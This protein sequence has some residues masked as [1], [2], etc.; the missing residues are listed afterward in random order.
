MP[1]SDDDGIRADLT[2]KLTPQNIRDLT[3]GKPIEV[4][5]I[6]HVRVGLEISQEALRMLTTT[7]VWK[8]S[9]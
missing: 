5:S 4:I 1:A 8:P 2:V 3:S 9:S 6:G 7:T